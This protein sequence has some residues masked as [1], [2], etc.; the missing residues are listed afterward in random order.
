MIPDRAET[1]EAMDPK[2]TLA[3]W[4]S[5][6]SEPA[7]VEGTS[8]G[9]EA[10]AYSSAEREEGSKPTRCMVELC[11]GAWSCAGKCS[12]GPVNNTAL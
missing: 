3:L 11:S 4:K 8:Q 9:P 12:G 7:V 10:V 6:R 5:Y 1:G 2:T